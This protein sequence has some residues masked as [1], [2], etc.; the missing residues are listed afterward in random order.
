MT[1]TMTV[2][3]RWLAAIR[4]QPVDRLPF[5]PKLGA[6]YPA[7]QAAPFTTMGLEALHDWI[8]S[9]KHTWIP[10]GIR[11]SRKATVVETH[12]SKGIE[13]T[14]YRTPGGQTELVCKFDAPSHSWHPVRF[15]VQSAEDIELMTDVFAD[16]T[17]ECNVE[18]LAVARSESERLDSSSLVCTGIGESPLMYWVEWLAGVENAHLLL[19]DHPGKVGRLFDAMQSVL[20]RKTE[21]LCEHSPA[22][23]FYLVENTSTTLISPDQYRAHCARHV[24]EIAG[25]VQRAERNLILHMCG[26]LKAL[27]PDLARIPVRAFEAFTSPTLGNTTFLDGRKMCPDKCLIGGTNAVLWTGT[28]GEIIAQLEEDLDALPHHRGIVV[29]SAG[30]MPP[31]CKPETIKEVCE[32]VRRYP[33]RM[34]H[35]T[36]VRRRARDGEGSPRACITDN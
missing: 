19:I 10:S 15:P 9:D 23:A 26:H 17:A 21:L 27:L 5:W 8:G 31:S 32:W 7:H 33:A 1:D 25:I 34:S 3:E 24:G 16:V 13:H 6:G 20:R 2:K 12:R 18:D 11:E 36:D 22:D 4:M 29:T 30:V 14:V 28:S 35:P